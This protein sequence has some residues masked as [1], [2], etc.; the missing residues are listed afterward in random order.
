MKAWSF[1]RFDIPT[2]WLLIYFSG[3]MLFDKIPYIC[4]L[5]SLALIV[6][7][8]AAWLVCEGPYTKH[9][10]ALVGLFALLGAYV[11]INALL[12]GTREQ[13][14]RAIYEYIV[15][16]CIFFAMAYLLPRASISKCLRVFMLW[17]ILIA[18]LS[19]IE[20]LRKTYL[21]AD[22]AY[23]LMYDPNYG[24]R[25]SVFSRSYLSHGTLLGIFSLVGMGLFYGSKKWKWLFMAAFCYVAILATASRGPLVAAG[26]ALVCQFWL[27]AFI[28]QRH[29]VKRLGA[30]TLL[31]LGVIAIFVVMFGTFQ[32]PNETINYF[33]H[34]IR[35]ITNWN[36]D[37]GNVGR[38]EIWQQ[39][40][41]WFKTNELFG[42]GP[43]K[44]GS[45][46]VNTIG[47]T[48][49]GVLKRL[50]ELGIV[51][52]ACYYLLVGKI[53]GKGI[54]NYNRQDQSGKKELLIW[55]GI[56]I[57]VLINDCTL[58][59]TEEIMISFF[60]YTALAGVETTHLQAA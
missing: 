5:A 45:W 20:Y 13:L 6:L 48:E 54:R 60:L 46:S 34:R 39:S 52:A 28:S 18:A 8:A 30:M 17:G 58:Q 59:V 53:L 27:N 19:W 50:C 23:N 11:I 26:A 24:F 47:V 41:Q 10:L 55:F 42:I 44:T 40:L 43:V 2:T 16:F 35:S 31:T 25:A 51:G 14:F 57:M 37:A 36:G 29:S 38:L 56:V 1:Q 33:L 7:Y 12:Q 15:Y 32:T 49:S 3:K 22:H 21:I 4:E 9:K